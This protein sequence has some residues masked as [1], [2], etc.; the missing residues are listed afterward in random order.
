VRS[1]APGARAAA[2][3]AAWVRR[4]AVAKCLGVGLGTPL[5]SRPF[6]VSDLDAGGGYAAA[7]AVA[8]R[9][10]LPLRRLAL[11]TAG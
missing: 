1:A 2:F 4:E 10:R 6:R 5:P 11:P 8:G 3:Y 7:V 9:E